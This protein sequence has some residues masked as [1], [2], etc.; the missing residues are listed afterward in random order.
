MEMAILREML[1]R[2]EIAEISWVPTYTQIAH[3]LTKKGAPSFKILVFISEP[4]ESSV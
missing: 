3:S 1:E 4:K 2:N